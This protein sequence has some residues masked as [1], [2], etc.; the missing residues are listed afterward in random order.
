MR[1]SATAH[2]GATFEFMDSYV[3]SIYSLLMDSIPEKSSILTVT[4]PTFGTSSTNTAMTR[5][6]LVNPKDRKRS[7][8]QIADQ[9]NRLIK[10]LP[11]AKGVVIQEQ[12]ISTAGSGQAGLP[13][14][15]VIQASD[16]EKLRSILPGFL[17]EAS[18]RPEFAIVDVNLKFTK[19]ELR[20]SIDRE[21]ARS[22]GVYTSDIAQTLQF[23][24]AGQRYGYFV[25]DG[26]QYQVIGQAERN[27]RNDIID[28][29]SMYVK[30]NTES[31]VQLHNVTH[32]NES[33]A[34]PSVYHYNR[35]VSAT[36]SAGLAEG[37]T[38]GDGISAMKSIAY[39]QLDPSFTTALTGPSKDF[40]ESSSSL[41]LL[42][43]LH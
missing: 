25:K 43:S 22:L 31:L 40:A 37:Y 17:E 36:V 24:L 34:P 2:E 30:S 28:I 10:Q 7:Q 5:L 27:T 38:L 15:F 39:T 26:R 41:L 9:V 29:Q 12:T 11:A 35:S 21:K 32:F 20:V 14:Q 1:I 42:L 13:V 8:M 6:M 3:H 16:L 33:S 23:A 18:K 19:P 4:S